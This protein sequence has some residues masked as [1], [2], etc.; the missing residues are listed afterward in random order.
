MCF[1]GD[2]ALANPELAPV[3]QKSGIS[4]IAFAFL[5]SGLFRGVLVGISVAKNTPLQG[6]Q[7]SFPGVAG[8]EQ[9]CPVDSTR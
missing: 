7:W 6:L 1:H 2:R 8:P 4:P 5:F 3:T 9:A